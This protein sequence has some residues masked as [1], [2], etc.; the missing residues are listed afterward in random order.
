MAT[1]VVPPSPLAG[2]PEM[3]LSVPTLIHV[4]FAESEMSLMIKFGGVRSR[5][6]LYKPS[7]TG[8]QGVALSTDLSMDSA[9]ARKYCRTFS[10]SLVPLLIV[11]TSK[12]TAFWSLCLGCFQFRW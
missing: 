5:A 4:N 12:L 2:V 1:V 11:R 8:R 10:V 9:A 7:G 6:A 3:R